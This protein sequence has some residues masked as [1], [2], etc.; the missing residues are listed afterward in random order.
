MTNDTLQLS[1]R[2][3][4]TA[5]LM[6]ILNEQ[7]GRKV[8][9]VVPATSLASRG[10]LIKVK[11]ST[12]ELTEDG[13][14]MADGLYRPTDVFDDGLSTKLGIPRQY[15]RRM[16]TDRP[17]LLDGN[18]NGWLHGKTSKVVNTSLPASSLPRT[19]VIHP[20]DDRAFLLRL[21]SG[22]E[23][24]EGVARAML[25]DK[26]G[27]TMDNIDILTAVMSGI[28]DSGVKPLIRVTDLS[29][30][31]MRVQFEFPD[32]SALAPGLMPDGYRSPFDGGGAT[33]AGAF[34]ELRQQY[35]AHHIFEQKD[36]PV[37]FLGFD[38]RNSET[39]G[40]AYTLAPKIVLVR[41]TNGW[42]ET[43]KDSVIRRVHLGARLEQGHIT[44]SA[45]TA[46]AAGRLVASE[47]QDAVSQWL[48]EGFLEGLIARR[49]EQAATPI[50]SPSETVPAICQKLG[51]SDEEQTSV[52]DLFITCGGPSTAGALANAVSAF[53]QT[54]QDVDR[55]YEIELATVPALEAAAAR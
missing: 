5:D 16:R 12:A 37:A 22:T 15:L 24:G 30:R 53:A 49:S 48:S 14:T 38:L 6:G 18:V 35:G 45:R 55:A 26:Y 1:A 23:G 39:G 10:G 33:R 31:N 47:T 36:A 29:E 7:A 3:A 4:T 9:L 43:A 19:E 44:A 27:I 25:S 11:G 34:S 50:T 46:R 32:R 20:A 17:D 54:V 13:V 8:D 52:L 41:C 51:F 2:N 21:F 40:G 28:A 42:T